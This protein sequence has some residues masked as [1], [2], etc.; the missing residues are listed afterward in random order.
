LVPPYPKQKKALVKILNNQKQ[1]LNFKPSYKFGISLKM[2]FYWPDIIP[3]FIHV[4][5]KKEI[6]EEKDDKP[7]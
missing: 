2:V 4:K 6:I 5:K 1:N 3:S 7:S